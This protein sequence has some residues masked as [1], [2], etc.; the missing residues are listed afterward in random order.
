M[1]KVTPSSL[2]KESQALMENIC[3]T[4]YPPGQWSTVTKYKL[5]ST[6]PD[7]RV[8]Y[9]QEISEEQ[10]LVDVLMIEIKRWKETR[11]QSTYDVVCKQLDNHMVQSNNPNGTTL[12]GAVVIGRHIQFYQK[13]LPKGKPRILNKEPLDL[14]H[15]A[16]TCQVWFDYFKTNIPGCEVPAPAASDAASQPSSVVYYEPQASSSGYMQSGLAFAQ[17]G[18][19]YAEWSEWEWNNEWKMESRYKLRED[20]EYDWEYRE[21]LGKGKG[22]AH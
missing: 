17:A 20:G 21:V 3:W 16:A 22:K 4:V 18:T 13:K 19:E 6:E 14:K 7:N 10:L 11:T 2:E 12:F 15:D 5:D 8:M 9:V 1:G